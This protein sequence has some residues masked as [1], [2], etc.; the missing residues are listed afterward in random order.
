MPQLG[1][2]IRITFTAARIE[3]DGGKL[4]WRKKV[5]D[6]DVWLDYRAEV[7]VREGAA[8][9]T[10]VAAEGR[11]TGAE[12]R[13]WAD[14]FRSADHVKS[15]PVTMGEV[16][17]VPI[18]R[19]WTPLAGAHAEF[20]VWPEATGHLAVMAVFT[21][22]EEQA[23]RRIAVETTAEADALRAFGDALESEYESLKANAS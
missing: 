16:P 14:W 20:I 17:N 6:Q 4:P 19:L 7:R 11:I 15:F 8:F 12:V 5:Q 21:P 3:Q 18:A 2:T 10:E 9:R 1:N 23:H 22:D 13:F